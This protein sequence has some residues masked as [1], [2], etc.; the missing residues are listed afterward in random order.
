MKRMA[1]QRQYYLVQLVSV[2][3]S[4]V[5][6][7]RRPLLGALALLMIGGCAI[8][9]RTSIPPGEASYHFVVHHHQARRQAFN[10]VELALNEMY[11]IN[12]AIPD[13]PKVL[14]LR[15]ADTGT[16]LLQPIVTYK[17]GGELGADQ[18][19]PYTLKI[20]VGNDNVTLDF[21]LG[22]EVTTGTWAPESEIPKIRG[23]FEGTA[24][25]VAKAV[26]GAVQ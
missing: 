19:A 20:V 17:A 18:I 4:I 1:R 9:T 25:M 22:R 10:N 6:V 13:F 12:E 24:R 11:A 5:P 14:K 8:S 7:M 23:Y 2:A 3:H 21:E 16:F 15:Q 26:G